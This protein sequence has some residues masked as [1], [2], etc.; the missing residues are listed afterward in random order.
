M[1]ASFCRDCL[2]TLSATLI[3]LDTCRSC[4]P[5]ASGSVDYS[6][7]WDLEPVETWPAFCPKPLA[8]CECMSLGKQ[9][10]QEEEQGLKWMDRLTDGA[11]YISRI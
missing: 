6:Q 2:R 10:E 11:K 1:I 9:W 4:V 5:L 3:K 7:G 8:L